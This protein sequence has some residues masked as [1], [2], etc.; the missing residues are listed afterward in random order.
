MSTIGWLHGVGEWWRDQ[1][2]MRARVRVGL[3][4]RP[5][6]PAPTPPQPPDAC[7]RG[8][9]E[10]CEQRP[11]EV[12]IVAK[13]LDRDGGSTG[14]VH[15]DVQYVC[16]QCTERHHRLSVAGANY[17]RDSIARRKRNQ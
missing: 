15:L 4:P 7:P 14:D 16:V 11:W 9:C 6:P 17:A 12:R 13:F 5:F 1:R 10:R 2:E 3:P 8:A